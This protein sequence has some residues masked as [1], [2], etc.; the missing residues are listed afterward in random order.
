[1]ATEPYQGTVDSTQS[2]TE[3]CGSKSSRRNSPSQHRS[4]CLADQTSGRCSQK[5]GCHRLGRSSCCTPQ[6]AKTITHIR[7][8]HDQYRKR[9]NL[10][11][12][13]LFWYNILS[14]GQK[15]YRTGMN[16]VK[17]EKNNIYIYIIKRWGCSSQIEKYFVDTSVK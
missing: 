5:P 11:P 6:T 4:N 17:R 2:G 13:L 12:F 9:I 14:L 15:K 8:C 3:G 7:I 10:V 16:S 1:M